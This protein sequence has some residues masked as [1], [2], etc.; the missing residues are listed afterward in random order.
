MLQNPVS[1]VD[2]ETIKGRPIFLLKIIIHDRRLPFDPGSLFW[3]QLLELTLYLCDLHR[4][5]YEVRFINGGHSTAFCATAPFLAIFSAFSGSKLGA[6][7][8]KSLNGT[9]T[10]FPRICRLFLLF[11]TP[12]FI[13]RLS[14]AFYGRV[15][16]GGGYG[17]FN[18]FC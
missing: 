10:G 15:C 12:F 7:E 4:S 3:R 11:I 9:V 6:R 17:Y 8:I 1:P 5:R 2:N 18:I 16:T 14:L 13:R